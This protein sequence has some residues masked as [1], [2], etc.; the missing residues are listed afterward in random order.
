[1]SFELKLAIQGRLTEFL[2][3]EIAHAARAVTLGVADTVESAKQ[4]ARHQVRAAGMGDRLANSWRHKVF[5]DKPGKF[6]LSAA[7]SVYS[8]APHIIDI[9]ARGGTI[10]PVNGRKYLAI[11]TSYLPQVVPALV[12]NRRI[13]KSP[14]PRSVA[15]YLRVK[16]VLRRNRH[17]TLWLE[18]GDLRLSR[19]KKASRQG[20]AKRA[21]DT[22]IAKGKA[23]TLPL[24]WLVK[25]VSIGK[26]LDLNAIVVH[27]EG[28][29]EANV[30]RHWQSE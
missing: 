9:Y 25:S 15:Q 7:G 3:A 18:A 16:L 30:L 1:M 2:S 10:V 29:L 21:S 24:F 12:G 6:S 8:K 13:G 22:A 17:G 19:S 11:P 4:L 26:R 27:M 5:P 14:T 28:Q 20:T 23:L